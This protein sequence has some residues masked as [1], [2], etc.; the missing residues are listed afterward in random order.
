[1]RRSFIS[2]KGRITIPAELRKKLGVAPG[3]SINW[4]EEHGRLVLTPVG[5]ASKEAQSRSSAVDASLA[6]PK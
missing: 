6:K 4:N 2:T 1:M 3:S 5:H